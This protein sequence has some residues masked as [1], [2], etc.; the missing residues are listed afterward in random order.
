[1]DAFFKLFERV[2]SRPLLQI[3]GALT[4]CCLFDK[5]PLENPGVENNFFYIIGFITSG[6]TFYFVR[7]LINYFNAG[8]HPSDLSDIGPSIGAILL[9]F[10]V[11]YVFHYLS[12]K[13]SEMTAAKLI[14]LGFVYTT[15]LLLFSLEMMNLNRLKIS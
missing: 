14:T 8:L 7:L 13:S 2:N 15:T 3:F 4:I 9:G 6:I 1:M 12:S 10:Y 11:I 5:S